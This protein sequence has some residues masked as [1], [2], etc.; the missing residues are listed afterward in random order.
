MAEQY[1][2]E[3]TG[4]GGGYSIPYGVPQMPHSDRSDLIDKIKPEA[5]AELIRHHL[6]GEE[7][8]DGNWEKV[9]ELQDDAL[10]VKGASDLSNLIL[11]TASINVSIS[12]L[13]D[14]EIKRRVCAICETAIFMCASNW[15]KYG[16]K[17]VGQLW[18]INQIIFT[19]ALVVL[20]QAHEASI[21]ELLKGTVQESRLIQTQPKAPSRVKRIVQGFLG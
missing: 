20:K 8:R 3:G 4:G 7:L 17:N 10:T 21:Q 2:D 13:E 6:L 19:N 11:A 14:H 18:F 1:Y 15:R 9:P 5:V 16:I 12:K